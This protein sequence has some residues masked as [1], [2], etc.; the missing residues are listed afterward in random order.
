MPSWTWCRA[1]GRSWTTSGGFRRERNISDDNIPELDDEIRIQVA[2]RYIDL[3]ERVTGSEFNGE[4]GDK[5]VAD[6]IRD[7]ISSYF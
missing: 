4:L 5:P 3:Y 2:E 6:R 1:S 7:N